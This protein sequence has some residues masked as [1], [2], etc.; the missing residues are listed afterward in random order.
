[1]NIADRSKSYVF[2][3]D[4]ANMK[5]R[6]VFDELRLIV[7]IYNRVEGT[8]FRLK[9]LG[10]LGKNNPNILLY[11]NRVA[12]RSYQNIRV[13]ESGYFDIYL[14]DRSSFYSKAN[15]ELRYKLVATLRSW[16]KLAAAN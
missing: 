8:K 13:A 12:G 11:R 1:M 6:E 5:Q 14:N 10:R 3:V 2:T 4:P 9:R 16:A 15:D 7:Q